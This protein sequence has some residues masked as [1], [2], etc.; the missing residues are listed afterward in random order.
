MSR[1]V[2]D[3]AALSRQ[4][5][6]EWVDMLDPDQRGRAMMPFDSIDRLTWAYVPGDRN[7][8]AIR[9]MS[10]AQREAAMA[11][12]DAGLS[13]RGADE[14]RAIMA[15]ERVLGELERR[16]GQGG[17][18]QRDP[19][20]YWFAIHGQPDPAKP[21]GWRVDGH[22]ISVRMTVVDDEVA[23]TPL[24]LGVNPARVPPEPGGGTH[25][26]AAEESLAR[27]LLA[28][29]SDA[30]KAI[31]V[32]DPVAPDDILTSN[33]RRFEPGSLPLGIAYASLEPGQRASFERLVRH[34]LA[35]AAYVSAA[36]A[37]AELEVAGLGGLTFAWAGP[38]EPGHGHYYVVRGDRFLIEYD[39]TQDRANHVHSVW[40]DAA[41]DWGDDLLAAHYAAFDHR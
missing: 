3:L 13:A 11:L 24:F 23:V 6:R 32:F 9:D 1:N 15:R 28:R 8:L 7:G 34:Y 38:E 2:A 20:R 14:V 31:A 22:H 18:A 10:T 4:L 12:V 35:R 36:T 30:Q 40:R 19:E 29:L 16:A 17:W 21:W 26:L 33:L 27:D 25:L 37:W 41:R 5:V 39:N